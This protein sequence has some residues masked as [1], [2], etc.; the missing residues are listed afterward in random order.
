MPWPSRQWSSAPAAGITAAIVGGLLSWRLFFT[1][2]GWDLSRDSLIPLAAFAVLAAVIVTT[3][4]LYRLSE[5]RHHDAQLAAVR[6]QAQAA[7]LFAREMAHRLKNALAIVQSIAV[8][9]LGEG[10]NTSKFAGRLK[11]LADA[12]D[13][14]SEH[15]ERPTANV[16]DVI[17]AT[18]KPFADGGERV[19]VDSADARI[20][21]QQVVSLALVVHELCTNASK[22]GAL[23]HGSGWVSLK[24]DDAGDRIRLV[25]KEHDGPQVSPPAERGFGTRLLQR[26]GSNTELAFE[27]DGVRC[28]LYLRKS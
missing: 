5:Q 3:S 11:A 17:D 15:V 6:R 23:S 27:P 26:V 21:A 2:S 19:R 1:P 10:P 20:A 9:T 7:E 12:H 13:L 4:H 18:L 28:C 8:Q 25:W 14:L 16:A 22:Y 24:V